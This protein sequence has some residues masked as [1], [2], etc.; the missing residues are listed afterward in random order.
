[1]GDDSG[2]R[3]GLRDFCSIPSDAMTRGRR[4]FCAGA[5]RALHESSLGIED[6]TGIPTRKDKNATLC[7]KCHS[8]CTMCILRGGLRRHERFQHRSDVIAHDKI[9]N[10]VEIRRFAIDDH[11]F[12]A[13]P[14]RQQRKP[15]R[16]PNHKR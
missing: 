16:R 4:R 9:C 14:F 3:P 1:M 5:R 15:G 8:L 13:A 2:S 12:C 6:N 10:F 7:Q 11:E